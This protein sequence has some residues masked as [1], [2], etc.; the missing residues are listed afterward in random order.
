M[1]TLITSIHARE[2]FDSRGRPTVEAEVTLDNGMSGRASVPSG[3]ST[4]RHEALELRDGDASN[5]RGLGV[6]H[7]VANVT[8]SIAPA[9]IGM[10]AADQRSIDTTLIQL[11]GTP[12]KSRL[13]ANATLA[14]SVATSRAAAA[15]AGVPA[16]RYIAGDGE[17]LLPMPMVNMIS[18]GLH[19]ARVLDV[20]DFLI[21]PIAAQSY[22]GALTMALQMHAA[23]GDEIASRGLSVLK[24]DEGGYGPALAS[25]REALDLLM[26][27]CERAGY[28][29]GVDVAFALDVAST[30]FFESSAG[31][32]RLEIEKRALTPCQL[33]D[34]LEEWTREYPLISIEDGLAEEDWDGWK[35]LTERLGTK[36]QLLGDDLFTT[37]PQRLQRGINDGIANAIL[38]KMNQIGTLTETLDVVHMA[39]RAGYATVISARSGETEDSFLADLAVGCAGGQ[40]KIGSVWSSE[41]MSKYNQLLRIEEELG[42][43]K[44][45]R[46][47]KGAHNA[48][49]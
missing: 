1:G 17:P 44:F 2:I 41:R 15:A 23:V 21:I 48:K 34:L 31:A 36:A 8:Q 33:V 19:A 45:A 38:V 20:Q 13:G 37:N 30:H 4:G 18:G 32:Y 16:W 27:A 25:N 49:Q 40:I 11:D 7:A 46:D 26:K 22:R 6:R 43:G 12:N 10:N 29:P 5:L 35:L 39:R 28:T 9:L 24:A 14:V 42:P 47:M 3:A